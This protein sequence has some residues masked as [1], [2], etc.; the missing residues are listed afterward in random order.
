MSD[1]RTDDQKKVDEALKAVFGLG[2]TRGYQEYRRLENIIK[3]GLIVNPIAGMGGR[4]GLKGT[5]ENILEKALKMGAEPVAPKRAVE[6]LNLLSE[7]KEAF[8]LFTCP[9]EMGEKEAIESGFKPEIIGV[10]PVDEKEKSTPED[11]FNAAKE[12]SVIPVNMI[13]FVGG[14][15]T[16]RDIYNGLKSASEYDK[17]TI[18]V[19][20]IPSGV[21]MYSGVFALNPAAGAEVVKKFI[22]TGLPPS[23]VEVMDIDEDKFRAGELSAKLYGYLLT[24]YDPEFVQSMKRATHSVDEELTNQLE[25]AR[26][27]SE[28]LENNTLYILCPGSTVY[29]LGKI[30]GLDKSLLGVDILFNREIVAKDVN[31]GQ[32]LDIIGDTQSGGISKGEKVKNIKIIV[33][34]IGGQGFIFGRGNQQISPKILERVGR[35]SIIVISTRNKLR[36]LKKL[37]VDTGDS[38]LD[39]KLKGPV[40]VITGYDEE[41]VIDI[42]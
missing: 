28:N 5:D 17:P 24:P 38:G 31:E 8:Q 40:K 26:Y 15:G 2:L 34:P 33:T 21:K 10:R 3:I 42:A 9:G 13:I 7:M 6:F 14:D 36:M 30:L 12:M 23:M 19:L 41:I 29:A 22:R 35:E 32:I 1:Q 20:G 16:A 4:V 27:V 18:P 11:T 37:R 25:I 39:N